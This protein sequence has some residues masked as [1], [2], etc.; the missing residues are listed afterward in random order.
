[1]TVTAFPYTTLFRSLVELLVR[2]AGRG[3]VFVRA[4]DFPKQLLAVPVPVSPGSVKEIAAEI[5]GALERT[6]R[7]LV[8]GAGPSSHAPHAVTNFA[9]VPSGAT[10]AAVAHDVVS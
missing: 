10:K 5:N 2:A 3:A 7:F 4:K 9:D 6:E 8:I 1:P